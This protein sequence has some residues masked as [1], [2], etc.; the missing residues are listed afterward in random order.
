MREERGER[1]E[2]K[3]REGRKEDEKVTKGKRGGD[4]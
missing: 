3:E 1:R 4:V 2:V